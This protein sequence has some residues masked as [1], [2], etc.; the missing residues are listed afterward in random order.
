VALIRD[1]GRGE[2]PGSGPLVL[3]DIADNPWTGGPGD[4]AELVRFLLANKVA[5]AAVALV[6][7]PE[8]VAQARAVDPGAT[9]EVRLGGKT[10]GL[11][12]EPLPVRAYVRLVSDGRYVNEGPMLAGVGVDLGPSAVLHCTS[13]EGGTPPVETLVTSRAETPIDLNVFRSHGIEPTRRTV[14]G[15]KG[16]G[17]FRASFEPIS[18][19]VALVEDPAS[20]A[21]T[22]RAW[23]SA[24]SAARS[25]RSTPRRP[26]RSA[27]RT[28]RDWLG[29]RPR[30]TE[31][32][33]TGGG[34]GAFGSGSR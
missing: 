19:R 7:D 8:T 9:I 33:M 21:P 17:H 32:T 27:G 2:L 24:T 25:G 26:T 20:P 5:G 28:P 30:R 15:L 31:E 3:V 23:R 1:L 34:G 11:H 16:K 12:G 22:S 18:R 14:L 29:A 13:P 4:S 10:D 6:K